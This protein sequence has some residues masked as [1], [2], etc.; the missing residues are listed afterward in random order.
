MR[1]SRRSRSRPRC[2][3]RP[4]GTGAP[5]RGGLDGAEPGVRQGPASVK[6]LHELL[7]QLAVMTAVSEGGLAELFDVMPPA[8][9]REALLVIVSTR[10]INLI[11]EAERSSRL[12][13]TSARGLLGRVIMLNATQGDLA[14][15]FQFADE[16]PR[17]LL[18]QRSSSAIQERRSSQGQRRRGL[19]SDD[20]A[21]GEPPRSTFEDGEAGS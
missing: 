8:V 3:S 20:D 11:E 4:A 14:A 12:S 19:T 16:P 7:E 21:S 17:D 2:A 1:L 5:D 10:P 6:L 13:G 18:Q 9:L 15:L